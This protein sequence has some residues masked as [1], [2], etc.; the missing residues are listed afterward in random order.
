MRTQEKQLEYFDQVDVSQCAAIKMS[1]S[2]LSFFM[3]DS[4]KTN[5]DLM[6]K[7][8]QRYD[9]IV[10][11]KFNCWILNTSFHDVYRT[12]LRSSQVL[13]TYFFLVRLCDKKRGVHFINV[14][15]LF[16]IFRIAIFVTCDD[17]S[18]VLQS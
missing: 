17:L 7:G 10:T 13:K 4:E 16:T 15:T 6:R 5:M 11:W 3:R 9:T 18:F 1:I 8:N 2:I 12:P 14:H